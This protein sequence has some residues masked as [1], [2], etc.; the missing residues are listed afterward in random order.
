MSYYG[1][2]HYNAVVPDNFQPEEHKYIK[3]LPG[4]IENQ[5]LQMAAEQSQSPSQKQP[6]ADAEQSSS[7]AAASGSRE[8]DEG[9]NAAADAGGDEESKDAEAAAYVAPM[10]SSANIELIKQA[11]LKSRQDFASR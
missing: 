7:A 6:E 3:T 1:R 8:G 2:S 10:K 11:V 5:D 9:G 4:E